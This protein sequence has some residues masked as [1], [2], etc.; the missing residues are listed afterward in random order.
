MGLQRVLAGAGRQGQGPAS[1]AVAWPQ[2]AQREPWLWKIQPA[3]AT[4]L[5]IVARSMD[6]G[7]GLAASAQ[8]FQPT[9]RVSATARPFVPG[10]GRAR[11]PQE[12]APEGGGI[13]A[14]AREFRPA[15]T[16]AAS[17]SAGFA[18]SFGASAPNEAT[19][20]AVH[21]AFSAGSALSSSFPS[22]APEFAHSGFGDQTFAVR[23]HFS[24]AAL[25]SRC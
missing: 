17:T 18:Q 25:W 21:G 5:P 4:C 12:E 15:V 23:A 19:A 2:A 22:A 10:G 16:A 13:A 20:S 8:P 9:S 24:D 11:P 7:S 3:A 1:A 14:S 6:P